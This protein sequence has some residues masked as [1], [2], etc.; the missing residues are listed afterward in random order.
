MGR[1]YARGMMRPLA[2][3]MIRLTLLLGIALG[4]VGVGFAHRTAAPID[5]QLFAFMEVGGTLADLCDDGAPITHWGDGGCEACRL[6]DNALG[7]PA[8]ELAP[9]VV[10]RLTDA[11][12]PDPVI[13]AGAPA[14][15]PYGA[16]AP[17]VV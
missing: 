1:A 3:M 9:L 14:P 12:R 4:L 6:T 11:G 8:M 10:A 2:H 15:L 7:P 13:H 16:R 17:P 5:P